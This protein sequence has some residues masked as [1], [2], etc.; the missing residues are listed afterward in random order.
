MVVNYNTFVSAIYAACFDIYN[1]I[2]SVVFILETKHYFRISLWLCTL[3][4]ISDYYN[5]LLT[6]IHYKC[7]RFF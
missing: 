3:L 2:F 1:V 4:D 6:I 7:C 5:Y